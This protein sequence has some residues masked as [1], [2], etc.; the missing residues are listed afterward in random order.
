[1]RAPTITFPNPSTALR[2]STRSSLGSRRCPQRR[3]LRRLDESPPQGRLTAH[4]ML[5]GLGE[6]AGV[7]PPAVLVVNDHAGQRVA[8]WSM[9]ESLG[10][11]V[12]EAD[13]G[14]AALRAVF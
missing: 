10:V 11:A 7:A 5:D 12:V 4:V 3:Q 1:M 6:V 13:S 9:L 14:R 8:I 2:S